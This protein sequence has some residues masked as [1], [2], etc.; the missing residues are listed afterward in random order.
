M[1]S[2]FGASASPLLG[3]TS[4]KNPITSSALP[5]R[6]HKT[7]HIICRYAVYTRTGIV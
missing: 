1:P 3:T 2:L 6:I 5:K 7:T 4:G